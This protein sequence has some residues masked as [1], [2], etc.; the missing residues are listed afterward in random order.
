MSDI[1]QNTINSV[2]SDGARPS[3][4]RCE[5]TLPSIF[6]NQERDMDVICKSAVFPT[7]TNE[8]IFIKYKGR[9]IPIPGQ[10]R[11]GHTMDL[12]FYMD[13]KHSHKVIFEEWMNGM[14]FENYAKNSHPETNTVRDSQ[15]DA[16]S[17]AKT[18]IRLTQLNFDGD[19]DKVTYVFHDVFPKEISQVQMGSETISAISEFNVAMVFSHYTIEKKEDDG[20]NSSD[21]SNQILGS[22]QATA[23]NVVD[24]SMGYIPGLNSINNISSNINSEIQDIG[25]SIGT[26]FDE[27]FT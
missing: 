13:E 21:T 2:I 16:L 23:N 4:Y 20:T 3:K 11:F 15:K 26:T 14:N 9:N 7:K 5:V 22:T 27:W 17:N 10:E 12:T 18:E 19:L 1:I 6:G 25:K 8:V 24:S